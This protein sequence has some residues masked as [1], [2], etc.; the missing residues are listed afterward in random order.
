MAISYTLLVG[1]IV[2]YFAKT[3]AWYRLRSVC[4]LSQFAC[5]CV[6]TLVFLSVRPVFSPGVA[7]YS[8]FA[9]ATLLAYVN[10]KMD[11]TRRADLEREAA[12]H[13]Q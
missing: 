11:L 7:C 5:W 12:H 1:G 10:F 6:L 2:G 13:A 8:A 3:R 4:L 9:L